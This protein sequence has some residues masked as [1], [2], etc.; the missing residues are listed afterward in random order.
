MY[1]L[2]NRRERCFLPFLRG[3]SKVTLNTNTQPHTY[4]CADL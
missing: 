4:L 3:V 1:S 2:R